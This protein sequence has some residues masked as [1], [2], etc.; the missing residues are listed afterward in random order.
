MA[1]F[2]DKKISELERLTGD[3]TPQSLFETAYTDSQMEEGEYATRAVD[4]EQIGRTILNDVEYATELETKDKTIFGAI[5]ELA[6]GGG[7]SGG[8]NVD[9]V[10]INGISILDEN[11]VANIPIAKNKL[12]AI[13]IDSYFNIN[14]DSSNGKVYPSELTKE[15]YDKANGKSFISKTTLENRLEP[16]ENELSDHES[17]IDALESGG[18]G[19]SA[20]SM[21]DN[22]FGGVDLTVNTETRTLST[23]D[24]LM[25]GFQLPNYTAGIYL[26]KNGVAQEDSRCIVSDFIEVPPRASITWR[27]G[28]SIPVEINII[29]YKADKSFRDW[30]PKASSSPT[31][32][33]TTNSD[34]KYIRASFYIPNLEA[35]FDNITISE[36]EIYKVGYREGGLLGLN[37]LNEKVEN[38]L[39]HI[40]VELC[41]N[42]TIEANAN[43]PQIQLSSLLPAGFDMDRIVSV[44]TECTYTT[45]SWRCI[46]NPMKFDNEY[47][48]II[49]SIYG[50]SSTVTFKANVIYI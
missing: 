1:E 47:Y 29:E 6:E 38:M 18:G 48:F 13:Q 33:I 46:C 30:Y 39:K 8:G 35:G 21:A 9:D 3:L 44:S 28:G 20:V 2:E 5:N 31:R 25:N 14:V 17:R 26:D 12:G 11:K 37:G 15:N 32:T 50:A 36:E 22:T 42:L 24:S 41:N 10:Q 7:G 40:Q 49:A 43:S 4:A 27:H 34:T 23:Q 16:I 19:G 45:G